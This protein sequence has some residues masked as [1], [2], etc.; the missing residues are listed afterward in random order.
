MPDKSSPK[1]P[2]LDRQPDPT[3]DAVRIDDIVEEAEPHT[4]PEVETAL[5]DD[6]GG[7]DP[8]DPETGEPYHEEDAGVDA[9]PANRRGGTGDT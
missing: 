8:M 4:N 2:P 7:A 1:T 3:D 5:D 9:P 6:E